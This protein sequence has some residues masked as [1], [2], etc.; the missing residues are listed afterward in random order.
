MSFVLHRLQRGG[1][2]ALD[3]SDERILA[4]VHG[5]WGGGR[6]NAH[7][8]RKH[9]CRLPCGMGLAGDSSSATATAAV[10][11]TVVVAG[12]RRTGQ[13]SGT[14]DDARGEVEAGGGHQ[15]STVGLARL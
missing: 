12:D 7:V 13:G 5:W 2:Q 1:I 9:V 15:R 10:V 3:R 6:S 14:D 11:A 8:E 4:L